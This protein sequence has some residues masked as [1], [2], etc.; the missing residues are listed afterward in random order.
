LILFFQNVSYVIH[1]ICPPLHET[2]FAGRVKISS[3][4]ASEIFT[5]AALQL[6]VVRK[7]ASLDC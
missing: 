6:V 2:L 4:E 1:I 3:S 7:T 5:H